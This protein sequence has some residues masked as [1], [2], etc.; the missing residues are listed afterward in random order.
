MRI[1]QASLEVLLAQYL[2]ILAACCLLHNWCINEQNKKETVQVTPNESVQTMCLYESS[3]N[4]LGF[5]LSDI[6]STPSNRS[7]LWLKLVE[8]ISSLGLSQSDYNAVA[9]FKSTKKCYVC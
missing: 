7:T 9:C 3:G 5:I 2:R 4:T 1:L 8:K 6:E